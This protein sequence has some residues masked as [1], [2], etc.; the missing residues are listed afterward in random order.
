MHGYADRPGAR[1]PRWVDRVDQRRGLARI[2]YHF[3][4]PS[5]RTSRSLRRVAVDPAAAKTRSLDYHERTL[6]HERILWVP[7]PVDHPAQPRRCAPS[8]GHRADPLP[9]YGLSPGLL[10]TAFAD[11]GVP[12]PAEPGHGLSPPRQGPGPTRPPRRRCGGASPMPGC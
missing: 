5:L 10:R 9:R 8:A 7:D 4:G 1:T 11:D 3:T 12:S 2:R 6:L